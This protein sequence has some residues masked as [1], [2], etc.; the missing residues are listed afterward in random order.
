MDTIELIEHHNMSVWSVVTV[1]EGKNEWGQPK[2]TIKKERWWK[3]W[4]EK[5]EAY[6]P[7]LKVAVEKLA[8]KLK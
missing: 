1:P 4:A 8:K 5:K 3:A 2:W 7:T 6:A